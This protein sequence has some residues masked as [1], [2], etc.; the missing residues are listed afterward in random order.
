MK[1]VQVLA[2][3]PWHQWFPIVSWL[4]R[5]IQ[6]SKHSHVVWYFPEMKIVRHAHFNDIREEDIDK[7]MEK[8]RLVGMQTIHLTEDQ[9]K[10]LDDF[11]KSKLGKQ[12][13]YF[14]TLFGELIPDLV[15]SLFKARISNPFYKG[16]TCSEFVREGSRQI[17]EVLVFVLT[18]QIPQGTFNTKDAMLLA[19]NISDKY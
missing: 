11:T 18:H 2:T 6:W 12:H 3:R 13:G 7:F 8:N 4:I 1:T 5:L 10:K 19:S 15:H 9:Y 17:D 14:T 16:M